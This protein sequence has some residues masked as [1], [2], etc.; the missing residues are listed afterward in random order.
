MARSVAQQPPS[1]SK[2]HSHRALNTRYQLL[3]RLGHGVTGTVYKA[4]DNSDRSEVAIKVVLKRNLNQSSSRSSLQR[5]VSLLKN[6]SHKHI[7]SF[8]T[9]FEDTSAVYIVTEFCQRGDLFS[10]L[11]TKPLP[12][13]EREALKY[14]RQLLH[15]MH[16]LNRHGVSHRDIK[17]EN[18]LINTN[19]DIKLADFGL[20]FWRPPQGSPYA[21]RHCG[22]LQYSAPEVLGKSAYRPEC[23]DMWSCGILLYA[24]L[25]KS[26]P[27][28]ARDPRQLTRQVVNADPQK[29]AS[30]KH[31]SVSRE[32]RLLITSLLAVNPSHRPSPMQAVTLV[33]NALLGPRETRSKHMPW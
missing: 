17:P 24:M 12:L 6:L 13:R 11:N 15:A 27:F 3:D 20:C 23:S 25:T 9:A 29:I 1:S 14:L 10:Y 30:S 26:L 28:T 31:L 32:C 5:E 21:S 16:Y 7:M 4:T 2:K 8:R 33:D 18:I 22:T 19:G